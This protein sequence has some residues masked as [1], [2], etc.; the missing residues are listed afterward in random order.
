[1]KKRGSKRGVKRGPYKKSK[2]RRYP[3]HQKTTTHEGKREYQKLLMRHK[4]GIS[5][6]RFGVHGRKPKIV[7]L[8]DLALDLRELDR[9]FR[10]RRKK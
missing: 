7:I 4:L 3:S 10:G 6:S 9:R 1:M 5:P 8:K 2:R